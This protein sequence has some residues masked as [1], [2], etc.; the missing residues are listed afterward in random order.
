M[1][2]ISEF[3]GL[4]ASDPETAHTRL[5]EAFCRLKTLGAVA[6]ELDVNPKAVYRWIRILGEKGY[7]DP[8]EVAERSGKVVQKHG[9]R[10]LSE[11]ERAQIRREREARIPLTEVA[12]RHGISPTH[13]SRIANGKTAGSR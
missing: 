4:V 13:V 10:H 3:M 6:R 9:I 1:P 11:R 12:R 2:A 5:V 8:R 7:G